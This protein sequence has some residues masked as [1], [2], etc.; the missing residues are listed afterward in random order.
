MPGT[1]TRS[2]SK[3]CFSPSSFMSQKHP[4]SRKFGTRLHFQIPLIPRDVPCS[5]LFVRSPVALVVTDL[6]SHTSFAFFIFLAIV[7]DRGRQCDI[8][9]SVLTTV[10]S[11]RGQQTVGLFCL[12]PIQQLR[13]VL[14]F[15]APVGKL[16]S[17]N[18]LYVNRSSGN[19][20]SNG[21]GSY[22]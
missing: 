16:C 1:P 15:A 19:E 10:I 3:I 9:F 13:L 7:S 12:E 8:R 22:P 11:W 14:A 17:F 21:C 20:F 2:P 18:S 4:S 6:Y 5:R